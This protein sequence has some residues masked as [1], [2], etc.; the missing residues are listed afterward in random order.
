MIILYNMA[1]DTDSSGP[2]TDDEAGVTDIKFGEKEVA[3]LLQKMRGP[4]ST[5]GITEIANDNDTARAEVI[6][7]AKQALQKNSTI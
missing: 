6:R 7:L 4:K 2:G 5:G 3:A 1:G